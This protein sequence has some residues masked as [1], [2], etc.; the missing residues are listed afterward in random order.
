MD[1]HGLRP[2]SDAG[3]RA[4]RLMRHCAPSVIANAVAKTFPV[5]ASAAWRSMALDFL[6]CRVA[7]LLAMTREKCHRERSAAIHGPGL[8]GNPCPRTS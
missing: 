8:R 2:R 3:R 5:I 7:S 6:D 4:W 1:C